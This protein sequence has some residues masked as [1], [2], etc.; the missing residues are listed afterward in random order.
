MIPSGISKS[1]AEYT[2]ENS[3]LNVM[4]YLNIQPASEKKGKVE[5][6]ADTTMALKDLIISE[7]VSG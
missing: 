6:D 5:F 4:I 3:S 2:N 7:M 1:M